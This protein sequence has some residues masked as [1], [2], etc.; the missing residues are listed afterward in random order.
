MITE[1]KIIKHFPYRTSSNRGATWTANAVGSGAPTAAA[2]LAVTMSGDGTKC[3]S[4]LLFRT[5][6]H[7]RRLV[8]SF[9]LISVFVFSQN[10]STKIK[11]KNAT[12]KINQDPRWRLYWTAILERRRRQQLHASLGQPSPVRG[13]MASRHNDADCVGARRRRRRRFNRETV[14][15]SVF[16]FFSV[17]YLYRWLASLLARSFVGSFVRSISFT[18]RHRR[19]LRPTERCAERLLPAIS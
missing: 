6:P 14:R 16:F 4:F 7:F 9:S 5:L 8:T 18:L 11:T 2:Y 3:V 1:I 12:A 13:P 17:S 15:D 10:A 19:G